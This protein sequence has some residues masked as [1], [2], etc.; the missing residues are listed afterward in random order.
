M[1][2]HDNELFTWCLSHMSE[3][4]FLRCFC[5]S[6]SRALR[7]WPF[8]VCTLTFSS[9]IECFSSHYLFYTTLLSSFL[10]VFV[11]VFVVIP[12]DC[13]HRR[14]QVLRAIS[15]DTMNPL[16]RYTSSA[17]TFVS[18]T[19]GWSHRLVRS[20]LPSFLPSSL[21]ECENLPVC[22]QP[23]ETEFD[24]Q[25]EENWKHPVSGNT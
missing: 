21:V 8:T 6:S 11:V 9:Q 13:C 2:F 22:N 19:S 12:V 25:L 4:F 10:F 23:D 18:I 15:H 1:S 14:A 16:I 17:S 7:Y 24:D 20:F 3:T 5:S